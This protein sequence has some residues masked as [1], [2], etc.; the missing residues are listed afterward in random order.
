[1]QARA[2]LLTAPGKEI[3][4]ETRSRLS[5]LI[6]FDRLGSGLAI[7]ARD[8]DLRGAG[9]LVG[10]EQAGHLKLVGLGLY[11]HLLARAVDR[12]R[13]NQ[14]TVLDPAIDLELS[15]SLPAD[16]VPE[17]AVRLNL[18]ARLQRFETIAEVEA[19]ADELEDRFG[20]PPAQTELLLDLARLEFAA[21]SAGIVKIGAGPSAIAIELADPNDPGLRRAKLHPH[22]KSSNGRLIFNIGTSPGP[23][24]LKAVQD[25]I[26]E[27]L[28]KT[29]SRRRKAKATTAR[30]KAD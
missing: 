28:R 29:P 21:A 22:C 2:F 19:F 14:R 3:P 24:R 9:D 27:F 10:E 1:V 20:R 13:G 15:G 7:S 8:L 17:A 4:E 16:Y 23:Q 6:A 5:T 30:R 25:L 26:Q 11:Q 18:Y 12:A